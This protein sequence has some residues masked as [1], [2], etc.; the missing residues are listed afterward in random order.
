VAGTAARLTPSADS[1]VQNGGYTLSSR[2]GASDPPSTRNRIS[3]CRPDGVLRERDV[4][5]LN[6]GVARMKGGDTEPDV[7][8]RVPRGFVAGTADVQPSIERHEPVRLPKEAP[9]VVWELPQDL[10]VVGRSSD[11]RDGVDS[12]DGN[13]RRC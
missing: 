1:F 11:V 3:G 2:P 7:P 6:A 10:V 8:E 12:T 5:R 9:Q 4:F 13:A